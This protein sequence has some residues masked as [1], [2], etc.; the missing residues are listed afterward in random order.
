MM[1]ILL[2]IAGTM[3]VGSQIISNTIN[4]YE[5]TDFIMD[6]LQIISNIV[7]S[8]MEL[9]EEDMDLLCDLEDVLIEAISLESNV[10]I[11]TGECKNKLESAECLFLNAIYMNLVEVVKSLKNGNLTA[12]NM[13]LRSVFENYMLMTA[14][15]KHHDLK[16][17]E[18]WELNSICEK[19]KYLKDDSA[20]IEED[21]KNYVD[22]LGLNYYSIDWK[23]L[24]GSYG[25]LYPLIPNKSNRNL[26]SL[27]YETENVQY[28]DNIKRLFVFYKYDDKKVSKIQSDGYRILNNWL[29]ELINRE[30]K[31]ILRN[32]MNLIKIGKLTLA[33]LPFLA[34]IAT[35]DQWSQGPKSKFFTYIFDLFTGTDES[36][37]NDPSLQ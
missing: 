27:Y 16:L 29:D 5:V 9:V 8:N 20:K 18:L 31:T 33:S 35:I 15:T 14:I 23:N 19:I 22:N 37:L 12:A 3:P 28:I 6:R 26:Y 17:A 24:R 30:Y 7:S 25:W 10:P 36:D 13:L 32:Y 34:A 21:L 11:H 1:L 2:V 4:R